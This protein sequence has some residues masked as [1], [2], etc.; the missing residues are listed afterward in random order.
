VDLTKS[1]FLFF[2][3]L[4]SLSLIRMEM[5]EDQKKEISFKA[6][7]KELTAKDFASLVGVLL[8]I[9]L[10]DFILFKISGLFS[11]GDSFNSLPR[12]FAG[13]LYELRVYIPLILFSI[14]IYALSLKA[15]VKLSVKRMLMLFISLWIVNVLAYEFTVWV[16]AYIIGLILMP[17]ADAERFYFWESILAIP[18]LFTYFLGY[19]S[20]MT[21]VLKQEDL[22][23]V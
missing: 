12:Y 3:A 2:V 1:L 11:L 13:L 6:F 21:N 19:Y 7:M 20:A 23:P 15:R 18:L 17:V 4:F 16:H 5:S 8:L 9:S 14:T 10:L 22:E